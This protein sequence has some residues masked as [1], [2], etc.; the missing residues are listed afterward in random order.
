MSWR[1]MWRLSWLFPMASLAV[2]IMDTTHWLFC[3]IWSIHWSWIGILNS[4]PVIKYLCARFIPERVFI[5]WKSFS[6]LDNVCAYTYENIYTWGLRK[7]LLCSWIQPL[8]NWLIC[9]KHES[10]GSKRGAV[11]QIHNQIYASLSFFH[12]L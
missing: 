10:C 5:F 12:N 8:L 9:S 3:A 4:I 2:I 7:S 6:V 11:Y 1:M